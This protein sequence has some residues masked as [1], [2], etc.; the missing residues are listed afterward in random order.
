MS[1]K[2]FLKSDF[3]K[4]SGKLFGSFGIAQLISFL[5]VPVLSR[6]YPA[7]LHGEMEIFLQILAIGGAI[8]TLK[9]DQAIMIAKSRS[10]AK[11]V[12]V[13]SLAINLAWTFISLLIILVFDDF[14]ARALRFSDIPNWF[15][16]IPG[17]LFLLGCTNTL[18]VWWN[19]ERAYN[20]LGSN[21]IAGAA[22]G[23][24]Y[25]LAHA[26][27]SI[28]GNGLIVG[29][30]VGLAISTLLFIPIRAA[31]ILDFDVTELKTVAKKFKSFPLWATPGSLVNVIGSALPV[32]A[33]TFFF[34]KSTTGYFSNATKLTFVPLSAISFSISQVLYERLARLR[35]KEERFGLSTNT[36]Q[37]LFFIALLPVVVIT[38]WGD[39]LVPLI[40]GE[41]WETAGLMA[42]VM[43]IF[44][45]VMYLTSPFAVAYE[46]YSR[47][48]VQ[49]M[50]T[51]L[52]ALL[53]A[54]ALVVSFKISDNV[55]VG[56]S[57][58]CL[59]GIIIRLA[60]LASCFKLIG[61]AI[62]TKVFYGVL[63][64]AGAVLLGF[65]VRYYLFG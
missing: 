38:V 9:Y 13:L 57:T 1:V 26:L 37:F 46:V 18:M 55:F 33:I 3:L 42:Q 52:F 39:I 28:S 20:R 50:F 43:V 53:T 23:G 36:L 11:S 15:Y 25:K 63:I 34:D 51:G 48:N 2:Q 32:L 56:L 41:G 5:L 58:F 64:I 62:L 4:N 24:G 59:T 16:L 17:A 12:L 45:F 44:Y 29:H 21:R 22:V 61:K 31:R 47:L 8:I 40:L 27:R 65:A 35:D 14:I 54:V 7:E 19:R 49:F 30:V 10:E 60:M 6:L